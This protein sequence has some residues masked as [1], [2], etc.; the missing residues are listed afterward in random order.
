MFFL[1]ST[2]SCQ[3]IRSSFGANRGANAF[4]GFGGN[5]NRGGKAAMAAAAA[6]CRGAASAPKGLRIFNTLLR[7]KM[8]ICKSFCPG[9][10]CSNPCQNHNPSL[11]F[12]LSFSLHTK[13]KTVLKRFTY[14]S[15]LGFRHFFAV[16]CTCCCPGSFC[17]DLFSE[18]TKFCS[19]DLVPSPADRAGNDA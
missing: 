10:F 19:F 15:L 1:S 2:I 14:L 9:S 3:Q 8:L 12:I 6:G 17:L 18:I 16:P 4:A 7:S 11:L 5:W 13:Q